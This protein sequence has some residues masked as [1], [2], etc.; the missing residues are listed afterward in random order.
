[1]DFVSI[2]VITDDVRLAGFYE[3]TPVR[4]EWSNESFAE[5]TVGSATSPS[6]APARPVFAPAP[7]GR[8]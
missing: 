3:G 4:G 7:R 8:D 2:R 1:M 6:P 5:F